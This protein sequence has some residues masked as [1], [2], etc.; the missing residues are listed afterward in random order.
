MERFERHTNPYTYA[1]YYEA[2]FTCKLRVKGMEILG[3]LWW[4]D[5]CMDKTVIKNI[6][7]IPLEDDD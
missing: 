1:K 5:K 3:E 4:Y 6:D 2:K 7:E